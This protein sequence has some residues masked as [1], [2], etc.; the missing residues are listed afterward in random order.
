MS[1]ASVAA[2]KL[3]R[4]I[5]DRERRFLKMDKPKKR[6]AV[7]RDVIAALQAKKIQA[8][9]GN[10][11]NLGVGKKQERLLPGGKQLRD[12]IIENSPTCT[13]CALG[14][15]FVC[16]VMRKDALTVEE[17]RSYDNLN[18]DYDNIADYLRAFFAEPQLEM[19]EV[20]FEKGT[21][22]FWGDVAYADVSS[23]GRAALFGKQ[24]KTA[25]DRMVAIMQN[26]IS[27]DG[28]FR[29]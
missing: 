2:K 9:Q 19:I 24:H 29:P 22:A 25:E 6:V 7:A 15:M 27:N 21:G 28:T 5:A 16:A 4:Q 3:Q 8:K 11:V 12:V 1:K 20:A 17:C 23:K 10:W 13:A 18:L 14:A 26:I